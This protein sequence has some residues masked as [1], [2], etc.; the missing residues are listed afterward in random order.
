MISKTTRRQNPENRNVKF[1]LRPSRFVSK[2]IRRNYVNQIR[3]CMLI[4]SRT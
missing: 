3:V 4:F 1:P 2:M